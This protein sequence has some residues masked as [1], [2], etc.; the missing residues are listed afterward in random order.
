MTNN[1]PSLFFRTLQVFSHYYKPVVPPSISKHLQLYSPLEMLINYWPKCMLGNTLNVITLGH[2]G[3]T[4]DVFQ[5]KWKKKIR[6]KQFENRLNHTNYIK[7][8]KPRNTQI[9]KHNL[10]LYAVYIR[11]QNLFCNMA[12][13]LLPSTSK[14]F[15]DGDRNIQLH[16]LGNINKKY[17]ALS[18]STGLG[19]SAFNETFNDSVPY[20]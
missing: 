6:S 16:F 10:I 5:I 8:Y 18:G 7:L 4:V 12:I 15:A 13:K 20:T 9:K 3:R 1:F 17:R 2:S 19:T 14:S 11:S